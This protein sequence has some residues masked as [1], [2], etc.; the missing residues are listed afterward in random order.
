MPTLVTGHNYLLLIS[1]FSNTQAGYSLSF[2]GGTANI[3]DP[4]NPHI[5]FA[6][7]NCDGTQIRIRVN[8]K[9]KC[10]SLTATG[11]EFTLTPPVSTIIGAVGHGCNNSFDMD[12]LTLT[13]NNPIPPGN[14][15]VTINN[16]TDLNSLMDNCNR[17]IPHG[18]SLSLIVLPILPTPM[19]SITKPGCTP[20][21]LQLVFRKPMKCSSVA[22]D[23]SDFTV[24]GPQPIT[25]L[26]A[27]G[28]NCNNGL[29][30]IIEVKL[31]SPIFT[32][33]NYIITLRTGTDGN[34]ILDECSSE[35]PAGSFLPFATRDTVNAD[36]TYS[37]IYGCSRDTI[38]YFHP[39][40]NGVNSWSWNF[41]GSRNSTQRNPQ[42]FYTLFGQ[43][44]T[45]LI[46]S[47]GVCRDTSTQSIL[48]NNEL[49]SEF[50]ASQVVCPGD[51]AS[52]INNSIGRNPSWL[53]IFGNGNISTV[54]NPPPQIYPA[55]S[56]TTDITVRLTVTDD[57]GCSATSTRIIKLVNNCYIAV[58]SAFTPNNDG[59]NDY[60]YPLN[61]YKARDLSFKV[62]NRFGQ[63]MFSTT[64]WLNKWDGSQQGQ[65]AE[66]GTYVWI[67]EFIN[68]DTN[69]NVK[70]KGTSILIR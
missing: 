54:K 4:T 56:A 6:E 29:S 42:I 39:G 32:Q 19:D 2:G 44:Q 1:H 59:L 50:E 68:T 36:F 41:D 14:Y 33:G 61:A 58:P 25:V 35:T 28:K 51:T 67:L 57:I 13:L 27:S 37:I 46:V 45:T 18:E 9:M 53:W 16:G 11:S 23:G 64:N 48:L 22:A 62:Y 24:T 63:L 5:L 55:P 69:I 30:K 7:A 17:E 8:K 20:D 38:N 65:Q 70:Q 34:T 10:T 21:I 12:S 52:F 60:L 31:S 40:L 26:S 43:K 3:T 49:R 66:M 15:T 47:N